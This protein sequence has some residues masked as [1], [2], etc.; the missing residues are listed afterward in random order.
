MTSLPKR[1]TTRLVHE[2]RFAAEVEIELLEE[3]HPWAPYISLEDMEK[4]DEVRMA[5]R[6]GDLKAAARLGRI[7]ELTPVAAE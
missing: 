3:D 7:F 5:L 6:R 4:L 1:K 2:G